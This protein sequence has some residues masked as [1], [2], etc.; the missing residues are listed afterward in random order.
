MRARGAL[1]PR[2]PGR[3]A[4]WRPASG[5]P[6]GGW[7]SRRP[8]RGSAAGSAG[9]DTQESG[10]LP[11]NTLQRGFLSVQLR[12][13][14]LEHGSSPVF[15]TGRWRRKIPTPGGRLHAGEQLGIFLAPLPYK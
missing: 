9:L 1:L 3:R 6:Q 10:F 7:R 11:R 15:A 14:P 13:S 2:R 4:T 5:A 8:K 12:F